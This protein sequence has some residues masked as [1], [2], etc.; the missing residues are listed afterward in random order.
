MKYNLIL[1]IFCFVIRPVFGQNQPI[2]S[3]MHEL[4]SFAIKHPALNNKVQLNV[5]GLPLFELL[6]TVALENN[7]N[8]TVDPT[9]NITVSYNFYDAT[10]KDVLIYVLKRFEVEYEFLNSILSIHKKTVKKEVPLFTPKNLDITYQPE[11]D[12]LSV[13]LKN[14]TL[15]SVIRKITQLSAKNIVVAPELRDKLVYGYF[16]NRPLNEVLELIAKGNG[17]ELNKED[18]GV[19][20]LQTLQKSETRQNNLNGRNGGN[21]LNRDEQTASNLIVEELPNGLWSVKS[22]N[23]PLSDFIQQF[24]RKAH[25]SCFTS[26]KLDGNVTIDLQNKKIDELFQLILQGTPYAIKKQGETYIFADAKSMSVRETALIRME[27]RTI[28][29]VKNLIP[30]DLLTDLEVNE[31]LDLNGLVVSGPPIRIQQLSDFLRRIDIVVPMVQ[32]DVMIVLSERGNTTKSGIKAGLKDKSTTTTGAV[33]PELN[34]EAGSKTINSILDAINGFGILNL[35]KVTENFY[36]SLQLLETNNVVD[37]E[38]TPKITT[39]NGHDANIS[40]GETTYYQET[41]VNVQNSVV[42]QG[43]LSSKIWK[44]I[45]ANLTVKIK[46]FVSADENVTLNITVNQ[47]DFGNKV[48]PSAPPNITKQSFESVVR[49]KNGEVVLLGGLDRN[50]SNNSGSGVPYLSR[51]PVLKWFFSSREKIKNKSKLHILIRPTVTY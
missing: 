17:L 2:E 50:R 5:S 10:V 38:S 32:I 9:L 35:G 28:E 37:V 23:T 36:M 27:N 16:L 39:L 20:Y 43:V 25:L 15:F 14:D 24:S 6:T 41:Q 49:V 11:N 13:D 34:I 4:D 22:M 42:N 7:L 40:I 8:F 47:D 19:F 45:D 30:K 18:N 44:S 3:Q 46:P 31:F 33:F 51:I 1:F 29:N 26:S 48:D 12:F 21:S